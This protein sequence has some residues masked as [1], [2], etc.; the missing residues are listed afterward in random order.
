MEYNDAMEKS[1]KKLFGDIAAAVAATAV[2]VGPPVAAAIIFNKMFD[3]RITTYDPLYFRIEDFPGLK[4]ER[5]EFISNRGQ[6]L[7]GYLYYREGIK[8]D[9]LVVLAHG[10]GGG[11]QRTYMDVTNHLCLNGFYVFAY[12]ATANDE[13][14]GDALK[15]FPQ[16]IID[17]SHAIDYISNQKEYKKYPVVLFGHSWGAYSVCNALKD[18]PKVKAVVALSGFN[19]SADLIRIRGE[20]YGGNSAES[21]YPYLVGQDEARFGRYAK[22]TAM[23][24][25]AHSEAPV[26]IIHSGDDPVVPYL[27][28][29]KIYYEKYKNDPRF[30]FML[31]ENRGHGTVYYSDEAVRYTREFENKWERF[32]KGKH[33]DEEKLGFINENINRTY[34]SNR[35]DKNLFKEIVEFYRNNL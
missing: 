22:Y 34:W 5:H 10:Y 30:K 13:S 23:D 18:N 31:Y 4:R 7:V 6:K 33:T 29:Y 3:H 14:G 12:D 28:G 16:G 24:S 9:A 15:G 26:F 8:K 21:L 2:T 20:G 32:N 25:F 27:A 19:N 35:I 17:L 1:K 11:G